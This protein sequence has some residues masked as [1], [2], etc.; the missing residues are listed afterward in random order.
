MAAKSGGYRRG[1]GSDSTEPRA[2]AYQQITDRMLAAI[3]EGTAPWRQ[4]WAASGWPRSMADGHAYQGTNVVLLALLSPWPSPWWGTFDQ[5]AELSGM[6][7]RTNA[8]TGRTYWASPDGTPRGVRKGEKSSKI[9]FVRERRA[10]DPDGKIDPETGEVALVK[11]PPAV[12]VWPVFNACQA[13]QLPER[14]AV[15]LREHEA[16]AGAEQVIGAY[17]ATGR[18]A[19]L[20]HDEHGRAYYQPAADT[21]HLPPAGEHRSG[22]EYYSTLMHELAHSTGHSSRLARPGIESFD[23]FGSGKY[24][25]EELT[26]EFA[27]AFVMNQAGTATADSD[28]NSAAYLASWR[29]AIAA[30]THLVVKAASAAQ[31]AADLILEPSRQA[32]PAAVP[33]SAGRSYE[34]DLAIMRAAMARTAGRAPEMEAV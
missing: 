15:K 14:F 23:H 26:A 17:L 27:A 1:A 11:I 28:A 25:L 30:D 12:G 7:K 33:E 32:Q 22:P 18:A 29:E 24:G 21:I 31:K 13:D 8:K 6:E 4:P 16:D 3:D 20:A 34:E 10:K 9:M 2:D 5:I 19:Q